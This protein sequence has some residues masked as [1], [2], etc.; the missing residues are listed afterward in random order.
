MELDTATKKSILEQLIAQIEASKYSNEVMGQTWQTIG[1]A[2]LA[3]QCAEKLAENVK[4]I[5]ELT[6]KLEAL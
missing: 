4:T 2:E 1:N 3:K 6:K 5:V